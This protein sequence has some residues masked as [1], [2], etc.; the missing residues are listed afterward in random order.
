MHIFGQVTQKQRHFETFDTAK[1]YHATFKI[2]P[3]TVLILLKKTFTNIQTRKVQ[4][5]FVIIT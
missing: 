4:K 1:I 5:Q 3:Y 2:I